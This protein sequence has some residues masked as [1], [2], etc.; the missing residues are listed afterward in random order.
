MKRFTL[1]ILVLGVLA[2]PA[3]AG[4]ETS[5]TAH[6]CSCTVAENAYARSYVAETA[7]ACIEFC[8]DYVNTGTANWY[9]LCIASDG[10]ISPAESGTITRNEGTTV[11]AD[12]TE[13]RDPV[14][15]N[16]N[17]PIP[18]LS[19]EESL[20]YDSAGNLRVNFLATYVNALYQFLI[21]AMA[22][23]AVVMLMI[24]GFQYILSRGHA[25]AVKKAKERMANAVI[26]LV[27]L[28]AA[29]DIAF[30][31]NPDFVRFE[32]LS[33]KTIPYEETPEE[34]IKDLES[35]GSTGTVAEGNVIDIPDDASKK[36]LIVTTR[37]KRI[38][39][40]TYNA[41]IAAADDFY[42][43]KQT[44]GRT[45]KN[46]VLTSASRTVQHQAELFYDCFA[47]KRDGNSGYCSTV[48]NPARSNTTVMTRSGSKWTLQSAY[49]SASKDTIIAALTQYGDPTV[50][51]HT[52][53][54]A[55]DVWAEDGGGKA[56]F[57]V[58]YQSAL[59]QTMYTNGFCRIPNEPWH[60]E[61]DTN[62]QASSTCSQ[63]YKNAD[64][65]ADGTAYSTSGCKLWSY[66]KHCCVA[67]KDNTS[68][69]STM[70]K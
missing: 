4:A 45:G 63:T 39:E 13:K 58:D 21:V 27:I 69:P 19:F 41:L 26:G 42:N 28:F 15:P 37:E 40:D 38:A 51:Y 35:Y 22:I 9:F 7:E 14:I 23:V 66:K 2:I 43:L 49:T 70:C 48:C 16:L 44:D 56:G 47:S 59:T 55:V 62:G 24:G 10:T 33:I 60:F 31:I 30:L 8:E 57:N 46:V 67:A 20:Y 12:K 54:I 53:N 17:V 61:L 50:C 32:A 1:A 64:Y 11:T 29:Y 65:K 36:H 5:C 3:F 52:N 6:A 34:L 68:K 18:G 25:D